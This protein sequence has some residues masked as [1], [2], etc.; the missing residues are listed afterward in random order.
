[1]KVKT[2]A[3]EGRDLL[4]QMAA[5]TR[6]HILKASRRLQHLRSVNAAQEQYV[7]EAYGMDIEDFRK[8]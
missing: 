3:A 2:E 4:K 1:M 8:K 7:Q 5:S 6:T